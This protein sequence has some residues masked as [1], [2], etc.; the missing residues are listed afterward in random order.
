MSAVTA[1]DKIL[2]YLVPKSF[3]RVHRVC[4]FF[5]ILITTL[6]F[7][8]LLDMEN[9]ESRFDF[10]CGGAKSDNADAV[11]GKCY[12]KYMKQH[13]KFG[14]PIYGFVLINFVIL[15][16]VCAIYSQ[17]VGP[18]ID[19]LSRGNRNNDLERRLLNQETASSTGNKLFKAYCYQLWIRIALGVIFIILQTQFYPLKFSSKFNCYLTD[20]TTQP[21]NSSGNAQNST[22]YDCHNQRAAKKTFW[23]YAVLSVNGIHVAGILFETVY[24]FSLARIES[25][26]MQDANFLKTYLSPNQHLDGRSI[27]FRPTERQ[28]EEPRG[29]THERP[30]PHHVRRDEPIPL[31]EQLQEQTFQEFIKRTKELIIQKTQGLSE[32]QSPF[33]GDPGD[34]TT[35]KNLTLDEIYTNLV[36]IQNIERY[37]FPENREDRLQLFSRSQ[38]SPLKSPGDLLNVKDKRVLVVGRPGIGK[39]LF[40]IKLLREWASGNLSEATSGANINFDVAFLVKFRSFT[41]DDDLS[42]R[43]LLIKS[44]YFPTSHMGDK[45]WNYL[46]E[47]PDGVLILFD[48]FDEFK[49]NSI[50]QSNSIKHDG[51]IAEAF[52]YPRSIE[53]KQP[54]QILHKWLV[55]GELLKGASVLT[56]SRSTALSGLRHLKF[57]KKYEILGFSSEQVEE[58]V[59]KFAGCKVGDTVWQHI[60]DNKNLLSLCYLPVNSFIVCT[61]LLQ[62]LQFHN[63]AG[64]GV[65]LPS[66]LTKIYKIAVKLFYVKRTKELGDNS[67]TREDI[68]SDHLDL[69]VKGKFEELGRVAFEG[70]K[71][72]ELNLGGNEVRGVKDS[73][74]FHRLPDRQTGEFKYEQQFCFIHLTIQEFFAARHIVNNMNKKEL[75]KFV[76]DNIGN[77]KWQLVFQFLAGLM[78]DKQH[79]PNKIITDLL[80]V[81]TEKKDGADYNEQWTENEKKRKVTSWPTA[82]ER[83]L[84]VTLI[85][86]FN[87]NSKMKSK[88]QRKLQRIKFNCVTFTGCHLT[89]VDCSTL[90]NV[91]NVQ[92][93]SHLDLAG[94]N[95]GTL[96]RLEIFELLKESQ[97]SCLT[98][99]Q[100]RL[101]D[102]VAKYLADAIKSNNCQLRTLD[103]TKNKISNIG[104]Q[105]LAE[106]INHLRTLHLSENN[107]SDTGAKYLAEAI[108]NNN[109]QL[110][111]LDLSANSIS[112][113][114]AKELAE[115]INNSNCLLH[116]SDLSAN[117]ISDTGAQHLADAINNKN[118]QLH[119]LNL[120]ENSISDTRAQHLAEAINNICHL[121]TL[122]L[123]ANDIS[124]IGTEDLA[125]AI[126]NNIGQLRTLDLSLNKDITEVGKRGARDLLGNSQSKCMLIF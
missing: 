100:N 90:V 23:M 22:L 103:L 109:C 117:S 54:L 20:G 91:I 118:C 93:I 115:A 81:K 70:L 36:V 3:H 84:A 46:Q 80:P 58:Y 106:A 21:R 78:E 52:P 122:N 123:S 40:C 85:K 37:D 124:D 5:W 1:I 44:E 77:S 79:L 26:F 98:L 125:K 4:V 72:R 101:T 59:H 10:S 55:T 49:S 48:G 97:L 63:S 31:T 111:T 89:A 60:D 116:T 88:A 107:I 96:G 119:T 67:F 28:N 42:L 15:A 43:E 74:L 56:T 62:I 41:S 53:D 8:V 73:A 75:G 108:N 32:L 82:D 86:C 12:Q 113:I 24:L 51:N 76:S 47:N 38:D 102:E 95:I 94:N 110:R 87:E 33:S 71:K 69:A 39:T 68:E 34:D 16:L 57:N 11:S 114:G 66:G 6:F 83:S 112:D 61:S 13:N 25:S 9:S 7:G 35:T 30:N 45:V 17:I 121:R 99:R 120:S 64:A 29:L 126:N 105:H 50:N 18:K 19:Q 27:T 2:E 65:T 104:A 14:F 92:Q